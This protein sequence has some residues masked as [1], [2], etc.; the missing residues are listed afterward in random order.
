MAFAG[1]SPAPGAGAPG[2][3]NLTWLEEADNGQFWGAGNYGVQFSLQGLDRYFEVHVPFNYHPANATPLVCL[4]HGGGGYAALMRYQT[5]IEQTA[6]QNGF[7]VAYLAGFT[8]SEIGNLHFWNTGRPMLFPGLED[9]NDVGYVQSCLL[10]MLNLWHLDVDRVYAAGIS[11]GSAMCYRL[12]AELPDTFAATA[13]CAGQSTA[14]E[15]EATVSRPKLICA[16][17]LDLHNPYEGG[18]SDLVSPLF[19]PYDFDGVGLCHRSWLPT[20]QCNTRLKTWR[21]GQVQFNQYRCNNGKE[22]TLLTCMDGGHTWPSGAVTQ[23][24]LEAGSAQINTD[25]NFSREMWDFFKR[26]PRT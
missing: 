26:H 3:V 23:T 2:V 25:V 24:E 9:V 12:S 18:A 8:L 13:H 17:L 14:E 21:R 11:N 5:R 20:L 4:L 16:G 22:A 19:E 15:F 6:E 10:G 1:T 7:L